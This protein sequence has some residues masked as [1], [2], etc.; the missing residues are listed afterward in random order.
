MNRRRIGEPGLALAPARLRPG[1][2]IVT[3]PTPGPLLS[4]R[5]ALL[6]L[7]A[8]LVGLAAGTLTFLVCGVASEP[9]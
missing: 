7:L 2:F 5:A 1:R 8:V 9:W 4:A 3:S 6:M